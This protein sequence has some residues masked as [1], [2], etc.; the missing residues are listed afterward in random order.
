MRPLDKTRICHK[1]SDKAHTAPKPR[2]QPLQ[3]NYQMCGKPVKSD[4]GPES[5]KP[6]T[7]YRT[8]TTS[9]G[10]FLDRQILSQKCG[11]PDLTF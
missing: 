10:P 4:L 3:I 6:R 5:S 1:E 2:N 8:P 7:A 11:K 9:G